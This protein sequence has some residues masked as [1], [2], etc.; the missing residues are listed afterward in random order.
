[1]GSFIAHANPIEKL[2]PAKSFSLCGLTAR[3]TWT[4]MSQ[5]SPSEEAHSC[6]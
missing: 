4:E 3:I 2:N 5:R 6:L 1:M